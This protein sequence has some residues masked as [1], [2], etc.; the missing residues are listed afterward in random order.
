MP[1]KFENLKV[2]RLSHDLAGKKNLVTR[3]FSKEDLSEL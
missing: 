2:W 3:T 1:F